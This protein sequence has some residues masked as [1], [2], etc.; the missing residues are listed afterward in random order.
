MSWNWVWGHPALVAITLAALLTA[1][2]LFAV[3]TEP[4]D[5]DGPLF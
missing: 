2:F 4:D 5:D 3:G 1:A